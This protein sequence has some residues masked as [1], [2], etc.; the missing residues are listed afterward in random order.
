MPRDTKLNVLAEPI[1]ETWGTDL[2]W[3][4]FEASGGSLRAAEIPSDATWL[5]RELTGKLL[6]SFPATRSVLRRL[7]EDSAGEFSEVV[8]TVMADL[9]DDPEESDEAPVI[10]GRFL[11]ATPKAVKFLRSRGLVHRERHVVDLVVELLESFELEKAVDL[12][13]RE[14]PDEEGLAGLRRDLGAERLE[15]LTVEDFGSFLHIEVPLHRMDGDLPGQWTCI[16]GLNG[17]G[18]SSLLQALGL[19]LLGTEDATE[20]GT[21][22]LGGLI[23]RGCSSASVFVHT[24]RGQRS[25]LIHAGRS[26]ELGGTGRSWR[27]LV[28][29]G[30]GRNLSD[31]P[32]SSSEA[33]GT[34]ARRLLTLFDPLAPVASSGLLAGT[35][36]MSEPS[37]LLLRRVAQEVLDL[38]VVLESGPDGQR[39]AEVERSS[40]RVESTRLPDGFRSTLAWLG[41][42]CM[43]WCEDHPEETAP[44]PDQV[45]AIVLLDEI[46]L[47]LH[48]SLQRSIVPRLRR[49]FPRVSWVVTTHSPLVLASFDATELRVLDQDEPRQ[50]RP[51]DRPVVGFSSDEVYRYLFGTEPRSEE[52]SH[53]ARSK[54][55][56]VDLAVALEASPEVDGQQARQRTE[57]LK[58]RLSAFLAK[59][60]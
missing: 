29:Y 38:M 7:D 59:K 24:N 21:Q 54:S 8:S 20:L 40:G 49:V 32:T 33:L 43:A 51:I 47:H 22:R 42:L 18:K 10:L 57:A 56:D 34:R 19:A 58:Q 27:T 30:A 2:K 60:K 6:T 46:D 4:L 5:D 16:A 15:A 41:D 52:W 17:A 31:R 39:L 53:Q 12:L 48:A 3:K 44:R 13:T 50:L 35:T 28:G 1:W 26:V 55:P 37:A 14:Y 11:R 23:R 36:A 25:L 9:A 45:D